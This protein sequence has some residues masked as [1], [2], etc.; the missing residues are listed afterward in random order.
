MSNLE[1]EWQSFLDGGEN[2]TKIA[3]QIKE[4][5]PICP[6]ASDL[7]ISTK[8]KILFLDT[9]KINIYKCFWGIPTLHFWEQREGII[10]KQIKYTCNTNKEYLDLMDRAKKDNRIKITNI[11][12]F[13]RE[14]VNTSDDPGGSTFK[15]IS[16]I[17]VGISNKELI[18][19]RIKKKGAFY[20]CLMLVIR[21]CGDD[22]IF[23]EINMKIFNTGKISFPGM[24]TKVQMETSMKIILDILSQIEERPINFVEDSIETV[25]INS[26]FNCGYFINRDK[27]YNILK[28]EYK[29][30]SSYDQCSYPGIQC[31]YFY[32]ESNTENDGRCICRNGCNRKGDGSKEG[33]CREISFMI[34]RT[35]SVLIVG[36]SD[37]DLLYKIYN[38]IKT[39]LETRYKEIYMALNLTDKTKKNLKQPKMKYFYI[40]K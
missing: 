34:F 6:N 33:N 26:N 24:L 16:K 1:E 21:I 19:S 18:N 30:H 28:F 17:T 25:L 11:K 2:D 23:K 20:N 9:K 8:V 5:I 15:D 12:H 39:I 36:K 10:K 35:G 14:M 27:L 37:E 13:E 40:N 4:E 22:G 29:L 38:F 3:P 7:R 32:N 31:K